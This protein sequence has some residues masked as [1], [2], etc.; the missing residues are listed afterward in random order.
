MKTTLRN[1]CTLH[2]VGSESLFGASISKR[3]GIFYT[4]ALVDFNM[5]HVTWED[6][7][8]GR[9]LQSKYLY[10]DTSGGGRGGGGGGGNMPP[11]AGRGGGGGRRQDVI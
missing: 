7:N 11:G 10:V 6:G 3:N 8:S 4:E 1:E 2:A 9:V 5:L